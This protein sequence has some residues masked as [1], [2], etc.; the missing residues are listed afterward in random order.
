MNFENFENNQNAIQ[1]IHFFTNQFYSFA[2]ASER[3]WSEIEN[4]EHMAT[5]LPFYQ[6]MPDTIDDGFFDWYCY[7]R[8]NNQFFKTKE[9]CVLYFIKYWTEWSRNGKPDW[10]A[11]IN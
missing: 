10:Q 5:G 6:L 3:V 11:A 9:M 2:V 4:V 7:V 1:Y 8:P